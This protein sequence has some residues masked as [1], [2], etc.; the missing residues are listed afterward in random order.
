[1]CGVHSSFFVCWEG[2][3]AWQYC[4]KSRQCNSLEQNFRSSSD[5]LAASGLLSLLA[6]DCAPRVSAGNGQSVGFLVSLGRPLH[7]VPIRPRNPKLGVCPHLKHGG[8]HL[9]QSFARSGFTHRSAKRDT[10]AVE[11]VRLPANIRGALSNL[12]KTGI[13]ADAV[14]A[15][16][17]TAEFC[18]RMRCR[19][20][21]QYA[22]AV[23]TTKEKEPCT[24]GHC[25]WMDTILFRYK[26]VFKI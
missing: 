5:A 11:N 17:R 1:M 22:Q 10:K 19:D 4:G 21:L 16:D 2:R 25:R 15:S 24:P 23:I 26:N 12:K 6:F 9:R 3:T 20:F 7:K 13:I 14:D 18:D 8:R